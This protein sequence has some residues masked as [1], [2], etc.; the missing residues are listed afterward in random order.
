M[1]PGAF[2]LTLGWDK[3]SPHHPSYAAPSSTTLANAIKWDTERR[4]IIGQRDIKLSFVQNMILGI[5][6]QREDGDDSLEWKRIL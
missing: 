6:N 4:R 1:L 2:S 5:G 3:D